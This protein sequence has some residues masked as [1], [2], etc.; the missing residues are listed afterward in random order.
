MLKRFLRQ[1]LAALLYYS[2]LL[3][4]LDKLTADADGKKPLVLMYHRVLPDAGSLL[5]Y[6]QAGITVST[7]SFEA[8]ISYL[9]KNYDVLSAKDF[10]R[11]LRGEIRSTRNRVLIT[12][13]DGWYDNFVHAYPIL[14][15]YGV[16]A[17]IL[18]CTEMIGTSRKFW[19]HE[20]GYHLLRQK[21][22]QAELDEVT[23]GIDPQL[24]IHVDENRAGFGLLD[25]VLGQVKS[26]T[27]EQIER[28]IRQFRAYGDPD[29]HEW[30]YTKVILDWSEIEAMDPAVIE[31]G[32][33]GKSHRLLT[34]ISEADLQ[35]ELKES[36]EIL[37]QKLRR[38][39]EMFA[40]PNGNYNSLVKSKTAESGYKCAFAVRPDHV[41]GSGID[42][43]AIPRL[44]LHEGATS[45][46]NRKF[47]KAIF[48]L[49]LSR[50]G[51]A[52]RN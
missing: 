16:S 14:K 49:L 2:G 7:A 31:I 48:A 26:W 44:G 24:S 1:S 36:K 37:E 27:P 5:E 50:A 45:G 8:Q 3:A 4:L 29:L 15:R 39:I 43:Y 6:T 34:Q 33:H 51:R 18:V 38:K 11:E 52:H 10:L 21:W 40:Y 12:F 35:T 19:F 28:L 20:I 32:S 9:K 13:D 23:T 30:D 25:D 47:S 42:V 46:L 22:S 17:T 41:P